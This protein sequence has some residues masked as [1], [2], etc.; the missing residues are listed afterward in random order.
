V[1]TP[2]GFSRFT[3]A[4]VVLPQINI[5]TDQIIPARYLKTT[6]RLGLGKAL[7]ADWRYDEKG[8]E[9]AGFPLND[10]SAKGAQILVAGD[11]FGCGSSREHAPWALADYGFRAVISSSIADIFKNNAVKSGVVPVVVGEADHQ[12]LLAS[13]GSEVTLDLET[14]TATFDGGKRTAKFTLDAFARHCLIHGVDEL[15]FLLAKQAEIAKF[16]SAPR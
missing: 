4:T 8:V 16:E 9:R 13:P 3:G 5:D 14:L 1:S 2:A 11:N 7:F 15:G 6:G 12:L 10:P